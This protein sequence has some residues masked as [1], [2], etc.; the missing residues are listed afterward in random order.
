MSSSDIKGE[1]E[2]GRERTNIHQMIINKPPHTMITQNILTSFDVLPSRSVMFS[3]NVLFH[4]QWSSFIDF[5]YILF[6]L[7]LF[8]VRLLLSWHLLCRKKFIRSFPFSPSNFFP[9]ISLSSRNANGEQIMTRYISTHNMLFTDDDGIHKW[10][11]M[12]RWILTEKRRKRR[13]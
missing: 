7:L 3:V 12:K 5:F 8:F 4:S 1:Y 13:R 10:T 6:W 9:L 11:R 2:R